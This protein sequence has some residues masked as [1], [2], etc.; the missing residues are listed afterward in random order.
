MPYPGDLTTGLRPCPSCGRPFRT[1]TA[2]C[3][4]CEREGVKHVSK[5]TRSLLLL[6][7]LRA[8]YGLPAI[9]AS[10][11]RCPRGLHTDRW[12]VVLDRL[13]TYEAQILSGVASS[14]RGVERTRR[15][16]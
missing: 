4:A 13:T 6:T 8:R 1:L 16:R 5:L 9:S 12:L 14:L 11:Q 3:R 10:E 7:R 2:A 15:A